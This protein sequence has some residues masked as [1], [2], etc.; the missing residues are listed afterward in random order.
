[1]S[2]YCLLRGAGMLTQALLM[3][4]GEGAA[5]EFSLAGYALSV[6]CR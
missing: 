2:G 1:M 3:N 4:P 5:C 6:L